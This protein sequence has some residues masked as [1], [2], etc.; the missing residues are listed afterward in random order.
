MSLFEKNTITDNIITVESLFWVFMVIYD[1]LKNL[2][3]KNT[4]ENVFVSIFNKNTG[5][6]HLL[7]INSVN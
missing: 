6:P 3:F 7:G 4:F 1:T 5:G 2:D